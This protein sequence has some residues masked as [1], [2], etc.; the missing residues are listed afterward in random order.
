MILI[1]DRDAQICVVGVAFLTSTKAGVLTGLKQFYCYLPTTDIK[2]GVRLGRSF[3]SA[4]A[5]SYGRSKL[6]KISFH[7]KG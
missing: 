7:Q 4:S 6:A 1:F 5:Y 2:I 3:R